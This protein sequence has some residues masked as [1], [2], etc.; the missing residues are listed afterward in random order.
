MSQMWDI[1]FRHSALPGGEWQAPIGP[2]IQVSESIK[3]ITTQTAGS[4]STITEI[5]S[6]E[7]YRIRIDG[8]IKTPPVNGVESKEFPIDQL[9]RLVNL[10]KAREAVEVV[11]EY[12]S[13]YGIR[14]MVLQSV[15]WKVEPGVPNSFSYAIT[16]ISDD[17]PELQILRF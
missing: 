14:Q 7:N 1:T 12:L 8:F 3:T 2:V 5:I 10:A 16:A 11:C 15:S 6:V 9:K 17:A 13:Y 4:A